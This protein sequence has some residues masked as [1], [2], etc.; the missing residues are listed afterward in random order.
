MIPRTKLTETANRI[1]IIY[2]TFNVVNKKIDNVAETDLLSHSEVADPYK[3]EF[4][5]TPSWIWSNSD[6]SFRSYLDG[7]LIRKIDRNIT[8][9]PQF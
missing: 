3:L 9:C 2:K 7:I 8:T 5:K 6:K 1:V 4:L